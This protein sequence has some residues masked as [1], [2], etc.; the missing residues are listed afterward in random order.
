MPNYSSSPVG[1]HFKVEVGTARRW[2]DVRFTEVSGLSAE[3]GLE[4]VPEGG[5]NRFVQKYRPGP[6]TRNSCQAADCSRLG[7]LGLV[8]RVYRRPEGHA[9]G[10]FRHTAQRGAPA[11]DDLAPRGRVPDE[12]GG[13]GL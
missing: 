10:G 11:T 13:V 5:E 2:H 8:P 9:E 12:M 3:M 7:G 1:F 4:D 6:N